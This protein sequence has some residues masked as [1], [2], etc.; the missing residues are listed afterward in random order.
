MRFVGMLLGAAPLALA[1]TLV[2]GTAAASDVGKT[3][4]SAKGKGITG[5]ALLGAEL[6][7][8]V[9]AVAGVKSPWAYV[10]GGVLGAAAGGVGGYFVEQNASPR[11]S[12]LL[13]AGGLTL[14]IPTIVGVLSATAYRP[15]ANYLTDRP[16]AD[17]PVA[18]P[19]Q[20]D[21]ASPAPPGVTPAPAPATPPTET[22]PATPPTMVP[23]TT[24]PTPSPPPTPSGPGSG[25]GPSSELPRVRHHLAA[26]DRVLPP[27]VL[28]TPS[29]VALTPG[30]LAL[31]IPAVEIQNTYTRAE[32]AMYGVKQTTEVH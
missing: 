32:L 31:R 6:V 16:P 2:T 7:C 21:L 17:E 4:A 18:N 24:P 9:E 1:A 30:A 11:A 13:L 15:P 22:N 19:P 5:G 23:P 20:P 26:R 10:G 14:V 3:E 12:M 28:T 25:A 8:S 27:L 29:L